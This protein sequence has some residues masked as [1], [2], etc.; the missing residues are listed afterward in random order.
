MSESFETT[1][2]DP[3]TAKAWLDAGDAVLVDVRESNEYAHARIDGAVLVP[4]SAFDPVA[5]PDAGGKK[6][7]FHCASGVRCGMASEKMKQAGYRGTIHRMEGGIQA[8]HGM[9]LPVIFG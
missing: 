5:V 1:F 3:V 9:G 7:I 6:L 4:L 2:I 8:W